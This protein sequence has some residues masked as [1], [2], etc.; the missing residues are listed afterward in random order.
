MSDFTFESDA[1][2]LPAGAWA[3]THRRSLRRRGRD[4]LG[5]TQGIH[6]PYLFP[7]YTPAGFA[8]TT[9]SPADHPHHDSVWI[10]SDHVH[11]RVPA[12]GSIEEYTY[13]LYG[14]GT[15][16]G[17]APGRLIETGCEST[18]LAPDRFRIT[19][20][21]AWRGPREWGADDGRHIAAEIRT[22]EVRAGD[23]HHVLDIRSRLAP[24][25]WEMS[26][27]PTRHAYFNVRVAES[28]RASHG[29]RL[30]DAEGRVGG[31]AITDTAT[32]WIDYSGPV[33]GG[34]VA[35]I[36]VF[37]SPRGAGGYWFVTDWGVVTVGPFRRE[38]RVLRLGEEM[39]LDYRLIV[40]D[41][42]GSDLDLPALYR[43]FVAEV[44]G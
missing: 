17:R 28:M 36:A 22:L 27:G 5:L 41:G 8:V 25:Q 7:L 20:E 13:N 38:A 43:E 44:G 30:I 40:H 39:V 29:G 9:E 16:Q 15:F 6:R 34:R 19:Q 35:G 31:D 37:P 18:A 14:N 24:T 23:A 3:R 11:C 10:A 12:A 42:D 21:I 4:I 26:L 1:I 2:H 33:G 32:A